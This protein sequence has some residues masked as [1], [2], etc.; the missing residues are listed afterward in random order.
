MNTRRRLIALFA[1]AAGLLVLPPARAQLSVQWLTQYGTNGFEYGYAIAVDQLGQSWVV[2]DTAGNLG[3]P[4]AGSQDIFLSRISAVGAVDF[5]RQ[6]GGTGPDF[7]RGVAL[8]GNNTVFAGGG[9]LAISGGLFDG[10]AAI[11]AFDDVTLR[12]GASGTWQGTTRFGSSADDNLIAVAGNAT[13][14]LIAGNTAGSFDGQT[15]V[16][17]R[18]AVVAKRDVTGAPVWTRFVGTSGEEIGRGAAFDSAGSGYVAGSSTGSF[19]GFTNAGGTD[20][21]VARYDATGNQT[22]LKQLGTS[23]DETAHDVEVDVSGNIYLTGTTAGALGGQGNAGGL[24]AFVMK[25]NSSGNVLWTRLLGGSADDGSFG[26][27]LDGAGHVW[28]G[29]YSASTFG[30]H[31]NA[32]D[33]DAFAAELDTD[34]NLLATTFLATSNFDRISGVS[35][36]PDGA[37]YMIGWT[38]GALGGPIAGG[39]D[40]FVAKITAAPEPS[41]ALLL[42]AGAGLLMR[43]R[44]G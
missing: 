33:F 3:G 30:G 26:L 34:G 11:G 43:R 21:F 19:S 25:L 38:A 18:D 23:S 29:G 12:Y 44:R 10:A 4:N 15:N 32:G 42:A 41:A 5:S 9:S 27:G 36:G 37:A 28:I 16:G 39:T 2:G 17:L 8:V 31:T 40:V 1:L 35:I 24:D 14:L 13:H 20:L 6:R 7:G 22:L